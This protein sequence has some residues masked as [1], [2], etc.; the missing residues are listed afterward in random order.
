MAIPKRRPVPPPPLPERPKIREAEDNRSGSRLRIPPPLPKR[1]QMQG[2]SDGG[3]EDVLVVAAPPEDSEP[4]TPSGEDA[5]PY[6]P[7][8]AEDVNEDDTPVHHGRARGDARL[9]AAPTLPVDDLEPA[10]AEVSP[11]T[12]I[13]VTVEDED[14]EGYSGWIDNTEIDQDIDTNATPPSMADVTI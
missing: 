4:G 6:I 3:D 5:R 11:I 1:R 14:D 8:W 9:E 7:P 13:P 2:R 10:D 12:A